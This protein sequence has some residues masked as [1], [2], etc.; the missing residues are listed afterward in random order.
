MQRRQLVRG[1]AHGMS[2]VPW[3]LVRGQTTTAYWVFCDRLIFFGYI[4]M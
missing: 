1:L 2:F 4:G 3:Q